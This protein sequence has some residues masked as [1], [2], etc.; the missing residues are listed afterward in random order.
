MRLE[1]IDP[2]PNQRS[3]VGILQPFFI[4]WIGVF[5]QIH[6]SDTFVL[7]DTVQF[8]PKTW[9]TRNRLHYGGSSHWLSVPCSGSRNQI[10][11]D[12]EVV[13]NMNWQKKQFRHVSQALGKFAFYSEIEP[14]IHSLYIQNNWDKLVDLNRW[15]LLEISQLLGLSSEW[16]MASELGASGSREGSLILDVCSKVGATRVINGPKSLDYVDTRNLE[17]NGVAQL[18]V[19]YDFQEPIFQRNEVDFLQSII[20]PIAKFGLGAVRQVIVQDGS[21]A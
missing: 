17:K 7:L 9:V 1:Q 8:T 11:G 19:D 21:D 16:L 14:F 18:T 12:V 5:R 4:P 2:A 15:A 3:S 20:Q 6:L 13:K 10:I